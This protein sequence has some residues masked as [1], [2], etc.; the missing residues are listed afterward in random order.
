MACVRDVD[1]LVMGHRPDSV[2]VAGGS[3]KPYANTEKSMTR[4]VASE[5]P[6]WS[7]YD[8]SERAL[9]A[10]VVA[11][12]IAGGERRPLSIA[13]PRQPKGLAQELQRHLASRVEPGPVASQCVEVDPFDTATLMKR[14]RGLGCRMLVIGRTET[15]VIEAAS[16][17]AE[18]PLVLV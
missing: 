11:A 9:I 2:P 3:K 5:H 8:G 4:A 13:V 7:I 10:V 18:W 1:L 6:V 15:N 12:E 17:A 14:I 16:K